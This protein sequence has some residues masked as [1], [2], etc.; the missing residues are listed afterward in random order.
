MRTA[1]CTRLY[2]LDF[3]KFRL[4]AP[5]RD[6]FGTWKIID[7][8]FLGDAASVRDFKFLNDNKLDMIFLLEDDPIIWRFPGIDYV[9]IE[10]NDPLTAARVALEKVGKDSEYTVLFYC[11]KFDMIG[12][13]LV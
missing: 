9:L 8:L 13:C 1:P 6:T 11:S 7:G 12:L 3:D 4:F 5:P 10:V 2:Q